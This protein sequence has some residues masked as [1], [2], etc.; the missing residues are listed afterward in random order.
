MGFWN[1]EGRQEYLNPPLQAGGVGY[2]A[3][4]LLSMVVNQ[5]KTYVSVW[6]RDCQKLAENSSAKTILAVSHGWR[7]CSVFFVIF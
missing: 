5:I 4:I 3:I 7:H 1:F 2:V 6:E